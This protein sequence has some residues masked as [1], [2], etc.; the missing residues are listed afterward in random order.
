MTI[1]DKTEN[2]GTKDYASVADVPTDV[3]A[4]RFVGALIRC[5]GNLNKYEALTAHLIRQLRGEPTPKDGELT[6]EVKP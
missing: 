6:P 1:P 3:L 2:P 4:S 5:K